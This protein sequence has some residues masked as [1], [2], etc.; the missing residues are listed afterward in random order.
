MKEIKEKL[1]HMQQAINDEIELDRK[2]SASAITNDIGDDIDHATEERDRE[3][4]QLLGERDRVKLKHIKE[5]IDRIDNDV[6]GEC[7]SCGEEIAKKR[8]MAL[9][10][11]RM[12]IDCKNE[13]ERTKGRDDGLT[14]SSDS[15]LSSLDGDF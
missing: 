2:K 9:P 15:R 14:E 8:L 12:C 5:A 3:L 4:Y 10:F 1:L 11:T 6:Y 13:E 7:D